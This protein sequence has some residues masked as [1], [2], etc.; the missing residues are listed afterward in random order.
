M[1]PRKPDRRTI[2]RHRFAAAV[3]VLSVAVHAAPNVQE[4]DTGKDNQLGLTFT[5]NG[6]TAFWVA[7]NGQWGNG[8]AGPRR[9]YRSQLRSGEWTPPTPMVFSGSYSDNGPFVSP[10]GQWLYFVSDRPT[11]TDDNLRDTNIWRYSLTEENRLELIS[12]NSDATE[13]SPVIVASGALYFASDRAGGS[14]QGDLYRAEPDGDGFAALHALGPALNT[15]TGEW[16]LWVSADEGEMIFEAS[17][18]PTNVST[19]GDLYYSWN[20]PAGWTPAIPVEPLNSRNSDLMVRMHPNGETLYYTSAEIGGHAQ[21]KAVGWP[22]MRKK[23]RYGFAPTLLVANRSSH[24][25]TFVDL[26]QGKVTA[27]TATGE[28]PHLLSN[29]DEN[30]VLATGYGVFPRPH[31]QPV[32]DRPPFVTATN[33]RATLIN[34]IDQ[35]VLMETVLEN[36]IRPHASWILGHK[37]FV[38]CQDEQQVRIID[39]RNGQSTGHFDTLQGGSHVLSFEPKSRTLASSNTGSGSITLINIDSGSTEIVE[40]AAGSEGALAVDGQIWVANAIDGSVS[41]V[42]PNDKAEVGRIDE[43]CQFPISISPGTQNLIWVACFAS[44]EL[45]A[46]DVNSYQIQRRLKLDQQPLNLLTH[47]TRNLAYVSYPRQ[48]AVG[49]I[50]L[51]SGLELRRIEVG[52]EPDGLRWAT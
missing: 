26:S 8:E 32:S 29:V 19:P 17:S 34:S 39:L 49:E 15:P 38:T 46:I 43:V 40:L 41:S 23:L 45:V 1:S 22:K 18:R 3:L 10:D 20:T 44:A 47:P 14:G 11:G 5:P 4:F 37:G 13:F 28:G 6:L 35:T 48:N 12:I 50:D 9:I 30:R 51:E 27:R 2:Q 24:E 52:I 33:S 21:M 16:N 31:V 7:W 36:C 42:D 25:V